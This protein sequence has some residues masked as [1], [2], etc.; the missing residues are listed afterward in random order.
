MR[1]TPPEVAR[2][3]DRVAEEYAALEGE[4]PWPRMRW[5]GELLAQL[6][7]GA[8]VL[9]LGCGNGV[10]ATRKIAKRHRVTGIDISER[11][12]ELARSNVKGADFRVADA[13]SLELP[14][15]SLDA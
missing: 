4:H 9:D 7:A 11:Q 2:G 8:D 3:Y 10:P 13:G 6:D 14:P 15:E 12:I 5:L 1:R